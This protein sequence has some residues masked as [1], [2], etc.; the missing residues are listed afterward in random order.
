MEA[1]TSYHSQLQKSELIDQTGSVAISLG[2]SATMWLYLIRDVPKAAT[3]AEAHNPAHSPAPLDNILTNEA[4]INAALQMANTQ[5]SD[6]RDTIKTVLFSIYRKDP[7]LHSELIEALG[8][9][10]E[11]NHWRG[12]REYS[13]DR[14]NN[15]ITFDALKLFI[16]HNQEEAAM[17]LADKL[18]NNKWEGIVS[19]RHMDLINAFQPNVTILLEAF[20]LR[21]D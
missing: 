6:C 10:Y 4:W 9:T 11:R 19:R 20:K 8:I 18:M 15:L 13:F 3:A 2:Y 14:H 1:L 21:I 7:S 17:R 5:Y 12:C 16:K